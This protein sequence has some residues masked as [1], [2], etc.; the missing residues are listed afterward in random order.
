MSAIE[1]G[2]WLAA[3]VIA[4]HVHP[5]LLMATGGAGLIRAAL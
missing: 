4:A 1:F 5:L 3:L 2:C